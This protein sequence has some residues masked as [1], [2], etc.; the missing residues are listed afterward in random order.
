MPSF[1]AMVPPVRVPPW[2]LHV[3]GCG[4]SSR[5]PRSRACFQSENPSR[6]PQIHYCENLRLRI[7]LVVVVEI[8]HFVKGQLTGSQFAVFAEGRVRQRA[9]VLAAE[10]STGHPQFARATVNLLWAELFGVG[11]VDPP[12]DF[13]LARYGA[14]PPEP[15]A[16][17]TL[18]EGLLDALAR[19]LVNFVE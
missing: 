13:D 17:Q 11:L 8:F 1:A 4:F 9:A 10:H 7:D 18:H 19:A 2:D 6:P 3:R 15:W 12:L 5:I 16:P 14:Q